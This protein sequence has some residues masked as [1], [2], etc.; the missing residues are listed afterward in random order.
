VKAKRHYYLRIAA[1]LSIVGL[2]SCN[3]P[4]RANEKQ[5]AAAENEVY[6]AVVR[7][8]ANSTQGIS[9]LVFY[10][11]R[12][13]DLGPKADRRSCEGRAGKNL[14]LRY[15]EP[16]Y[17]SL[18]DRLYRAVRNGPD[19]SLSPDTIKDSLTR[20]CVTAGP[21]SQTFHTD[22][23]KSFITDK[24]VHF[25]D[26]IANDGSKPFEQLFPGASGIISFSP[27]GFD[28]TL[29]EALV[30]T[31]FVCGMLCGFGQRY[32]LRKVQGHWQVVDGWTV[33]VS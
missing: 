31:S 7:H 20:S 1:A 24:S 13:T 15:D 5:I 23:P 30:S 21:L 6:E 29:H 3:Y 17:N 12:L 33:W 18:A 19:Y 2:S 27:V 8:M 10:T 9:Q 16:P 28:S 14:R 32:V 22:L 25:N 4:G 26:V 11:T